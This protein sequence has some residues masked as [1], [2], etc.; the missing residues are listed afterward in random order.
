MT[1]SPIVTINDELLAELEGGAPAHAESCTLPGPMLAALLTTSTTSANSSSPPRSQPRTASCSGRMR[2][3][4]AMQGTTPA[5][6][7]QTSS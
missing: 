6:A 7:N 2:S 3:G 5:Q 1:T 4:I